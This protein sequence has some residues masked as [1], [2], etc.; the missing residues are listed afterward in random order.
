MEEMMLNTEKVF[1]FFE[2][3]SRIP[4]G[5]GNTGQIAKYLV[6]FARE[7]NL[8]VK[9]DEAGN[10]AIFKDASEGYEKAGAVIL[11]GHMDMVCE[12]DTDCEID[13]ATEG[14]SLLTD[15]EFI[16]ADGTT[17]GGDDGI[18]IAYMLA[19]LDDGQIPHPPLEILIT[20][21]EEVGL[22]G[23][24]ALSIE[25]FKAKRLINLDSEEEG[26]LTV[27]CAG[28]VRTYSDI[29]V[30]YESVYAEKEEKYLMETGLQEGSSQTSFRIEISNLKGGHSGVDIGNQ[31][32]NAIILM[33]RILSEL[34]LKYDFRI[35]NVSCPGREN[36]IPKGAECILV[37]EVANTDAFT[38][39]FLSLCEQIYMELEETES[40]V[41][42]ELAEY[43]VQFRCLTLESTKKL[44]FAMYHMPDGVQVEYPEIPGMIRS[45]LNTGILELSDDFARFGTLIRSN[46]DEEKQMV[47]NK[48]KTFIEFL[49]GTVRLENDY[50]AWAYRKD[51]PLRDKMVQIFESLYGQS[52]KISITHGGLECGIL[53]GRLGNLDMVSMGPNLYDVHTPRERM[54]IAS[55]QRTWEYLLEI[56]GNMKE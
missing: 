49:G 19:L 16:F 15:G 50:P 51:S 52:P 45:S 44:I 24:S 48:V 26:Y 7:R 34:S 46:M 20:N 37:C 39:D 8:L 4:H 5:S 25:G 21:D 32:S 53:A 18:A 3:I 29:P 38:E 33:G 27:S 1:R 9:K 31:R 55:V 54:E 41:E 14:I 35:V 10:I 12:K 17:L 23:A 22:A 30:E 36:V 56:L 42:F 43:L 47:I 11:Q 40:D 13:M 6:N 2:E 28:A